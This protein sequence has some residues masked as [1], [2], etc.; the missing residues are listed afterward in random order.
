MNSRNFT[1]FYLIERVFLRHQCMRC[2]IAALH[3]GPVAAKR[4]VVPLD[5]DVDRLDAPRVRL[6]Q[7]RGERDDRRTPGTWQMSNLSEAPPRIHEQGSHPF[8]ED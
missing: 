4:S 8:V 6:L 7:R 5:A 3:R 1:I 2:K